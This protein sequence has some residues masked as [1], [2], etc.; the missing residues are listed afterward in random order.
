VDY[1]QDVPGFDEDEYD[2]DDEE[3]CSID[4]YGDEDDFDEDMLSEEFNKQMIEDAS[5]LDEPG[6]ED[7][8]KGVDLDDLQTYHN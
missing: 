7:L 8:A 5:F 6:E 4:L 1:A 3:D 2:D